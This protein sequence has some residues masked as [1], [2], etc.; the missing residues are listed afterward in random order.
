MSNALQFAHLSPPKISTFPA[1]RTTLHP[2]S[3]MNPMPPTWPD[4]ATFWQDKRMIVTG[5]SGFLGS[6]IGARDLPETIVRT[7]GVTAAYAVAAHLHPQAH[8]WL[9]KFVSWTSCA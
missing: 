8:N 5:G 9:T 3:T 6:L 1:A 7:K 2:M 4:S